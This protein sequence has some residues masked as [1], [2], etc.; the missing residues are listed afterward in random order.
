MDLAGKL[1]LENRLSYVRLS[2]GTCYYAANAYAFKKR[3]F[4]VINL[5]QL[6]VQEKRFAGFTFRPTITGEAEAVSAVRDKLTAAVERHLISD[7]PIGLFLSGGI[8]SSLLTLL[9]HTTLKE[10]LHTVSIVFE[11]VVF[12]EAKYQKIIIDATA[13][14]TVHFL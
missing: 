6:T 11:D 1:Q 14:V 8:D 7:A 10:R 9:A 13:P 5:P 12:S 4:L 3:D 2:A